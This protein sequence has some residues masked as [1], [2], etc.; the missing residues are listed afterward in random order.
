MYTYNGVI[1]RYYGLSKIHKDNIPLRPILS[2]VGSPIQPLAKYVANILNRV[3]SS[4]NKFRIKDTFQFSEDINNFK[5]PDGFVLVSFDVVSLFTN[6]PLT[7]II[8]ILNEHF[9]LIDDHSPIPRQEFIDIISYLYNNTYIN[10]DGGCYKEIMG[11]P[12]SGATSPVLAEILMNK[13]L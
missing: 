6:I 12:M 10:F 3:F 1:P 5:L 13:L 9:N 2:C 8:S 4:F 11:L 7:L